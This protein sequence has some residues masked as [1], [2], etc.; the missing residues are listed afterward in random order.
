[1]FGDL[2]HKRIVVTG[3]VTG[4]GGAASHALAKAGA[5]VFAQYLGGGNE[6]AA[7]ER[8]GIAT[9]KLDLLE[10]KAPWTLIAEAE[11]RLGGIDVLINN[12]GGMVERRQI[13]ELDDALYERVLDLNVRQLVDCCRAV[14]PIF[15]KQ[16]SGNIINVSSIAAR[17]GGSAG[18]GIYAG[19][20]GFVSAV[21]KSMAKELAPSNIRVNAVSPGTIHTAFHDRHSTPDKLEAT[22]LQIPLGRLGTA[23]DCAGTFVYLASDEA[24][25]YVTGQVIEVNGGL[26]MG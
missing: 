7:F 13:A 26:F 5:K 14:I 22:R 24:S 6:A 4:I 12:A 25:G 18:S 11:K 3:G 17:S 8:Q 2:V 15:Q 9:L 19:S 21:T 20:K 16:R 23:E 1:M 10:R